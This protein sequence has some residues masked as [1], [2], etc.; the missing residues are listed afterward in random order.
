M[1]ILIAIIILEIV[2]KWKLFEKLGAEGWKSLIPIYSTY[3]LLVSI[4]LNPWWLLINN[5]LPVLQP[6]A[7]IYFTILKNK[8][9]SNAFGRGNGTVWGLCLIPHIFIPILAF[10]S[11]VEFKGKAPMRDIVFDKFLKF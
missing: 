6:A 5:C 11:D 3:T 8:S 10:S 9:I 4:G 7:N 2:A 1:I